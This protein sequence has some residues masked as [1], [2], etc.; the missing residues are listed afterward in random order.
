M[1]Q[2]TDLAYAEFEAAV[3]QCAATDFGAET[4]GPVITNILDKLKALLATV[5]NNLDEAEIAEIVARTTA[6]FAAPSFI[7]GMLLMAYVVKALK[8]PVPTPGVV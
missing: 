3:T 2:A 7:S 6:F 5:S 8:S 4:A 1:S